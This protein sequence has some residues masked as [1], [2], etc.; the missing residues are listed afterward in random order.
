MVLLNLNSENA[1]LSFRIFLKRDICLPRLSQATY[2]S[3]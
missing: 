1:E 3:L 2:M